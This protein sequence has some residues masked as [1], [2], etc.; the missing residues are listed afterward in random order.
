MKRILIGI[1][2]FLLFLG[3]VIWGGFALHF[4]G[5]KLLLFCLI[6][7]TLGA[8]ATFFILWYLHKLNADLANIG[9]PD[10][11]DADNLNALL[12]ASNNRIRQ[13]G[14]A[15]NMASMPLIYIVGDENSAKTQTVLQSGLDPELLAGSVFQDGVIVPTQLA[16]IWLAGNYIL[17]EA[18]GG[19]LRR[20]ALWLK[21]VKATL[22]ARLGSVFSRDSRLPARSV[23]VCVSVERILAPSTSEQIRSLAQSLNE[24]LRQLSQSLGVSLPV[25]VLFTKLDNILPFGSYVGR[26]S[27]EE[28]KAP[29]GSLLSALD[30]GSGVYTENATALISTRFDHLLFS[31][32]EFRLDVLSRG[33]ELQD[34]ARAYEFPRDLRK[35]RAGIVSFLAEVARPSQIGVNPFLRGFFFTG[36]RAHMVEDVIDVGPAQYQ[37]QAPVDAGATRIFSLAAAQSPQVSATPARRGSVRKVPQWVFLPQLFSRILFAD[38]SALEASRASTRTSFLKRTLLATASTAILA[39]LTLISISFFNNRYLE[40][41]VEDAAGSQV[42]PVAAGGIAT[43]SDLQKLDELRAVLDELDRNRKE[44]APFLYGMGLYSGKSLYPVACRA[45]SNKFSSLLLAPSLANIVAKLRTVPAIPAADADYIAT[46]RPLKAY[47]IATSDTDPDS[48]QDTREFLPRALLTEWAGS[49]SPSSDISNLALAQFAFY[50]NLLPGSS[51]CMASAGGL[52][53][54]AAIAQAQHYLNGFQGY[55]QVYLSMLSA[56]NRKVAGFTFNGRFPGTS[57]YIVDNYPVPGAFTKDG[58]AFMQAA[59]LHPDSY[60]GGEAWVLKSTNPPIDRATLASELRKD[61]TAEYIKTWRD[62]LDNAKVTPFLS[63]KDAGDKLSALD[64]NNSP[65]LE[66]FSLISYN[67]DVASEEISSAFQAPRRVIPPSSLDGRLI[68]SSNQSYIQSLQNLEQAVKSIS[69]D[70]T[71][72]NDPAAAAPIIPVA[73]SA[74]GETKKIENDFT[75]DPIGNMDKSSFR[76][77]EAPITSTELLAKQAP[78]RAAGAGAKA[79]CAQIYPVLSKFP[80]NPDSSAE[81][82]P[83]E[84]AAVFSPGSGSFTTFSRTTL[85]SIVELH[86]S[87]FEPA[88]GSGLAI[89]SSFLDFLNRAQKIS[90][91]LFPY[92][93]STPSLD[94]SLVA[95]RSQGSSN[96]RLSVDRQQ[97]SGN[98]QKVQFHWVSKPDGKTSV[99]FSEGNVSTPPGGPWSVFR[100]GYRATHTPPDLLRFNQQMNNQTN[101]DVTFQVSGS[102]ADLLDKGFMKNFRCV[103]NVAR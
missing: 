53:N 11:A 30:S 32:S 12:R 51:S 8:L 5:T 92:G 79:F 47:L 62:Y 22:P 43:L 24:R 21:L 35:L 82:S 41:R 86:G 1:A 74:H 83:E 38:K 10:S 46:Y 31:L 2:T 80:F 84:V 50:S 93:G 72:V 3:L 73:A 9:G 52:P 33:G 88:Q 99:A 48:D 69:L 7:G 98:G 85:Q 64:L 34:L 17:V 6:L 27:E 68:V 61:Y 65:L 58:F 44:G 59:I 76:L 4:E 78:A 15:K 89:N 55:K 36:M 14:R 90:A 49:A 26:L 87:R 29:I 96:A 103:S 40:R 45:Y 56:A 39:M 54:F 25:Y 102:G 66:L 67:T 94:F 71:K 23:V 42:T 75:I 81:D 101:G 19:L 77:L 63:F 95:V 16:N 18:A 20:P 100:L 13:G 60:F 57:Q 70:P 28:V 91:A 37:A 97:V